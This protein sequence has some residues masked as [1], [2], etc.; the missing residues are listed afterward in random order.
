M[1]GSG[2]WDPRRE[3]LS[4]VA[5]SRTDGAFASGSRRRL[6]MTGR[7]MFTTMSSKTIFCGLLLVCSQ[8]ITSLRV[9]T[10]WGAFDSVVF[11]QPSAAEWQQVSNMNS[12]VAPYI[13]ILE[14]ESGRAA[15]TIVSVSISLP[16]NQK[17][18]DKLASNEWFCMSQVVPVIRHTYNTNFIRFSFPM[19]F[20]K[21]QDK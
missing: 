21:I 11:R 9:K 1:G 2:A 14:A 16:G 18:M 7:T 8:E 20:L 19:C 13:S 17:M 5:P 3:R 6:C 4:N 10:M 12:C 15:P